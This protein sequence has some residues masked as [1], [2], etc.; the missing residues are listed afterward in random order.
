MKKK[1]SR[2]SYSSITIPTQQPLAASGDGYTVNDYTSAEEEDLGGDQPSS[3]KSY[4][5]DSN[6]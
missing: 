4:F 1:Y 2:P 5:G 3:V 6:P